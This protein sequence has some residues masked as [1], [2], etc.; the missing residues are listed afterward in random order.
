MN[1]R[2]KMERGNSSNSITLNPNRSPQRSPRR[3]LTKTDRRRDGQGRDGTA[4]GGREA[5]VEGK[6]KTRREEKREGRRRGCVIDGKKGS[7]SKFRE[8]EKEG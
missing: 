5:C 2:Q 4:T 8:E 1:P 6:R 7:I 3:A